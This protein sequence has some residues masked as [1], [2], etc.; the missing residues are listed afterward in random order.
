MKNWLLLLTFSPLFNVCACAEEAEFNTNQYLT[1][2]P[3]P[4][5]TGLSSADWQEAAAAS[6]AKCAP[7]MW[8]MFRRTSLLK[9]I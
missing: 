3:I 2:T 7:P 5:A 1:T 9:V 6:G 8:V 4:N